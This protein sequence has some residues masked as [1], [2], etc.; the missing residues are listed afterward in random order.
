ME[1]EGQNG[2][3]IKIERKM[4]FCGIKTFSNTGD[5]CGNGKGE[6]NVLA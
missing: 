6:R 2:K 1:K 4:L 5:Q 3:R